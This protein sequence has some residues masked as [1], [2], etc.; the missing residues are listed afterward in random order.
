MT[1]YKQ[2]AQSQKSTKIIGSFFQQN[3]DKIFKLKYDDII[4]TSLLSYAVVNFYTLND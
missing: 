4:S 2:E 1:K 3:G